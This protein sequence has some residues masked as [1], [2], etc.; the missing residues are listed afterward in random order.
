MSH[1]IVCPAELEAEYREHILPLEEH[2]A[3]HAVTKVDGMV[4]WGFGGYL[5]NAG[6]QNQAKILE[7]TRS[8]P[9]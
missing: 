2:S 5:V 8:E 7:I 4:K 9:K 1:L 3:F 6:R